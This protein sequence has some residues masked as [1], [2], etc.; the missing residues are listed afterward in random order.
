M[1]MFVRMLRAAVSGITATKVA[2]TSGTASAVC[3][4]PTASAMASAA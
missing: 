4:A 3:A 1:R 2:A